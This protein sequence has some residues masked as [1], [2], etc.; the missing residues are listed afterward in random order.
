MSSPMPAWGKASGHAR[1]SALRTVLFLIAEKPD[2][3]RFS[4]H[5]D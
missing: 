1:F 3:F 4:P 5:T 2:F